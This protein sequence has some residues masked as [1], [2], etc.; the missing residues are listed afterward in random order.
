MRTWAAAASVAL[1]CLIVAPPSF[2]HCEIPC[3]IYDDEARLTM[4]E[5]HVATIEKSMSMIIEL[6]EEGEKNYNQL[7]RW[8]HNKETHASH[9]QEIVCQ[10]FLTQRVKPVDDRSSPDRPRY[11]EQLT[12][13][14]E[15][16]VYAMKARQSTDLGHAAKLRSLVIDFR[17]VCLG[18][19]KG[20]HTHQ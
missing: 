3:G 14:H 20:K 6:S 8:I 1:G 17:A 9:V 19:G 2:S 13:L 12:L 4:I 10:Y 5:E 7:V 18:L 15:M 16:L 11:V